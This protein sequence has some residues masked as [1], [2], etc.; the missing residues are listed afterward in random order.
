[1]YC[2]MV[3][4]DEIADSIVGF[5]GWAEAEDTDPHQVRYAIVEKK[6]KNVYVCT[7][8]YW[9]RVCPLENGGVSRL[10]GNCQWRKDTHGGI[11]QAVRSAEDH[12]KATDKAYAQMGHKGPYG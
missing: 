8:V 2:P 12:R 1:M 7:W 4:W 11:Q 5:L 10:R 3:N 6:E 9:E